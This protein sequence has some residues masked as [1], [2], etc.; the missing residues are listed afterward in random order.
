MLP[1]KIQLMAPLERATRERVSKHNRRISVACV[2]QKQRPF[3][4]INE[5]SPLFGLNI[6][7]TAVPSMISWKNPM[8]LIEY[9]FMVLRCGPAFL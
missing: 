5:T 8:P 2:I 6:F 1:E 7:H 9:V 4:A 3:R